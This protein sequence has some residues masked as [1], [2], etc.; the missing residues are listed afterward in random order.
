V[1][2]TISGFCAVVAAIEPKPTTKRKSE[3]WIQAPSGMNAH[4][5]APSAKMK[6][7]P[8]HPLSSDDVRELSADRRAGDGADAGGEQHH[9][10]LA[11]G[12]MPAGGE[13]GDEIADQEE[14]VE[15]EHFLHDDQRDR[16]VIARRQPGFF[17]CVEPVLRGVARILEFCN[18]ALHT[19]LNDPLGVERYIGHFL[20]PGRPTAAVMRSGSNCLTIR[21]KS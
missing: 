18:A 20:S 2:S 7:A 3:N 15:F 16:Q 13:H 4:P 19:S 14:V 11:V 8:D 1:I 21:Q 5:A 9:G 10:A 12:E 17:E 6:P